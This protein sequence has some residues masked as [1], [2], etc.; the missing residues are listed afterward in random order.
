M[1]IP[2]RILVPAALPLLFLCLGA[3]DTGSKAQRKKIYTYLIEKTLERQAFSEVKN[4]RLELAFEEDAKALKSDFL[5]AKEDLDLMRALIMMSNAR[6]DRNV[7]ID[8]VDGGYREV[9]GIDELPMRFHAE[10]TDDG[11][12]LFVSDWS[13]DVEQYTRGYT[14]SVGDVVLEINGD[15]VEE[16]LEEYRPHLRFATEHGLWKAFA[17]ELSRQRELLDTGLYEKKVTLKLEVQDRRI[18]S[19]I[20]LPYRSRQLNDWVRPVQQVRPGFETVLETGSFDV[21]KHASREVLLL[22]LHAFDTD[23]VDDV[24]E[25]ELFLT[26][27][28]LWEHDFIVDATEART[29]GTASPVPLLRVLAKEPFHPCS[30]QVRISDLVE[31]YSDVMRRREGRDSEAVRWIQ[32]EVQAAADAGDEWSPATPW[33][34]GVTQGDSEGL[35]RPAELHVQGNVVYLFSSEVDG[36]VDQ[37]SALVIDGGLGWSIG[38]PTGGRGTDWRWSETL[39]LPGTDKKIAAFMWSIAR[40]VRPNGELL[41]GNPPT[42]HDPIA[43]TA[44]SWAGW[45]T[46]VLERALAYLDGIDGE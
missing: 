9:W 5:N 15:D 46:S 28:E 17:G 24:H 13:S 16:V 3:A 25:L 37:L 19:K 41:D 29:G 38:T 18:P 31:E 6:C 44:E 22:L 43:V 14:P 26:D 27:E 34:P 39:E 36:V 32:E 10:V 7:W 35:L 11:A 4:E 12:R 33:P 21:L 20:V 30:G 42:P 40:I 45:Y 2:L 1:K 8:T 23:L